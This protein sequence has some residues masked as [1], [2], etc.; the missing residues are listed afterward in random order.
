MSVGVIGFQMYTVGDSAVHRLD[1]RV[2]LLLLVAFLYAISFSVWTPILPLFIL[3]FSLILAVLAGK[4]TFLNVVKGVFLSVGFIGVFLCV[5]F[6]L[7]SPFNRTILG[8]LPMIGIPY[9]Y[10]GLY[11]A[12]YTT[13]RIFAL[14]TYGMVFFATTRP[15]H[16][17]KSLI[18]MGLPYDIGHMILASIAVFPLLTEEF[19]RVKTAQQSRAMMAKGF[20]ERFRQAVA[21]IIPVVGSALGRGET[22]AWVLEARGFTSPGEKTSLFQ[23][24]LRRQDMPVIIFTLT[25]IIVNTYL[26][27]RYGYLVDP[28]GWNREVVAPFLLFLNANVIVFLLMAA[29]LSI[30]RLQKR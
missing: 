23:F 16:L 25:I 7:Y 28:L 8:T 30:R 11:W 10:E 1:P 4:Q 17:V 29:S 3:A 12:V 27:I 9:Y 24:R 20:L 2:K 14:F 26:L 19:D 18:D 22:Q 6:P 5:L 21:L 15:Q 13:Y